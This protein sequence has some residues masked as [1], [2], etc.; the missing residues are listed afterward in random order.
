M[1][2]IL[3]DELRQTQVIVQNRIHSTSPCLLFYIFGAE[4]SIQLL[5]NSS[6]DRL[7]YK[8]ISIA[9]TE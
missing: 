8:K 6:I 2:H 7:L 5:A 4:E 3:D 1:F 9:N